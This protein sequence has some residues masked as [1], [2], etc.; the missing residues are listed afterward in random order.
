MHNHALVVLITFLLFSF[1]QQ[2]WAGS[3]V[4][5][6][7]NVPAAQQVSIDRI[8][9]AA[10]DALLRKYCDDRGY[11]NYQAWHRSP[12][13]LQLLEQYPGALVAKPPLGNRP[14]R[15]VSLPFGSMPTMRLR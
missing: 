8:D 14:R 12:A 10:W 1:P 13:D 15:R 3:K 5:V 9:H 7:V 11:V 6:G 4:A 2:L